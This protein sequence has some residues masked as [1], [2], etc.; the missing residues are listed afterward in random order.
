VNAHTVS[1]SSSLNRIARNGHVYTFTAD[2]GAGLTNVT[3][4]QLREVG[5]NKASTFTGFC[6]LH[7]AATFAPVDEGKFQD[8]AEHAFLLG[9]RALCQEIHKK[10]HAGETVEPVLRSMI[11]GKPPS[12][13]RSL[14][15]VLD[16]YAAGTANA[17]KELKRIKKAYDDALQGQDYSD[18]RYYIVRFD[19]VPDVMA[20]GLFYPECDFDGGQLQLP[21]VTPPP[22]AHV[23]FNLLATESGGAAVVTWVGAGEPSNR[24]VTS[25]HRLS[26]DRVPSAVVRLAFE[27]LE[28]TYFRPA[29]WESLSQPIVEAL[30]RRVSAGLPSG[31]VLYDLR[32][33]GLTLA[34]WRV[35]S[36]ASNVL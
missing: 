7:D 8:I 29:W 35:V 13:K 31:A 10:M 20:S 32:E 24:L 5:V 21:G 12:E 23:T 22:L 15:E 28:N 3:T 16:A 33:D 30:E 4:L 9:Y 17:V 19:R 25:F 27:F 36:R 14:Q 18:V 11:R 34:D 26:V 6:A 2:I 1:R